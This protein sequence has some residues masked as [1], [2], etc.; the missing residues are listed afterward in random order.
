MRVSHA[1][2]TNGVLTTFLL[3]WPPGTLI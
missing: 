2:L 1:P 3:Y